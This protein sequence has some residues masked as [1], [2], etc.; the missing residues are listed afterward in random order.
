MIGEE[1]NNGNL[2]NFLIRP[3]NYFLYWFSKDIG[4]K[5]MNIVFSIFEL[6]LLFFLLK[7][8]FFMQTNLFYLLSFV[9]FIL[10]AV[11]IYFFI[12]VLCGSV[13]FWTQDT[14]APRFLLYIVLG[15][16]SGGMFPLDILPNNLYAVF[17]L[18]P[19]AYLLYFPIKIYL[20][21]ISIAET[22]FRL[23]ISVWW[24][25]VLFIVIQ[26]V[27]SKGLR[28]YTAQGK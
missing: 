6:V 12:N 19:F 11:G 28:L 20:G 23:F 15:F 21:Q 7:P 24:N 9:F 27:W 17:S 5:A 22:L 18:S 3:L 1:I 8:D 10:S 25:I 16:L 4:D 26:H 2:S 13:G 14:W